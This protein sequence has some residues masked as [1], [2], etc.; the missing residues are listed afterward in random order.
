[1]SFLPNVI[2]FA[3]NKE[4]WGPY[5]RWAAARAVLSKPRICLGREASIG[6]WIS[7]SE[8]L[9][10]LSGISAS[11]LCL[12]RR[13]RE[14]AGKGE[15]V[16]LDVGANVGL[17]TCTMADAGFTK[18]HAFEP[19]PD[20]FVRLKKNVLYNK[21]SSRCILNCLG[22]GAVRDFAQFA[23]SLDSPGVNRLATSA[24]PFVHQLQKVPIISL[25]EYC[26]RFEI[27]NI[28]LAKIDVEGMEELVLRGARELL[29]RRAIR[30]ILIEI[31]PVNQPQVGLHIDDLLAAISEFGYESRKLLRDGTAG[32][33]LDNAYL[34]N[35][36][37][38]NVIL[39]PR[40]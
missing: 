21:L 12:L 13:V 40:T 22:V 28:D 32:E 14:E 6:E 3:R 34:R 1:M 5:A 35:C 37:S 29:Q 4:M 31:A 19:I 8:Y 23:E 33:E 11:E 36:R 17:F 24:T 38:E 7:F 25:D 18:V 9:Y 2:R 10:F 20:T 15:C 39:V 27:R 26:S 30:K 16:G